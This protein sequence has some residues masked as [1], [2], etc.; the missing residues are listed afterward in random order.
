MMGS[1]ALR[2]TISIVT[3]CFNEEENV[4]QCYETVRALFDGPDAPLARYDFE[5]LFCD[6]G[7]QDRTVSILEEIAAADRRVKVIVNSRNFGAS[8]NLFNGIANATGDAVVASIAADLQDPP[9]MIPA[10]VEQWENGYEVVFGVRANRREAPPLTLARRLFYRLLN[11]FAPFEIPPDVGDFHLI[12]RVVADALRQQDDYYPYVRGLIAYSGFRSTGIRYEMRERL[13]GASKA[14]LYDLVD[15]ALNAFVSFGRVPMRLCLLAGLM[16]AAISLLVA[17]FFLVTNILFYRQL[18][19][20]GIPTLTIALFFF[21][22]VQLFFIG[23]LG[24]YLLATHAQVRRRPFV[25]ERRRINF[26]D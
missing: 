1:G 2:K 6:N 16:L 18:A 10:F 26:D 9:E 3:P 11:R 5:Y 8:L 12:D 20:P 25:I 13:R 7:S 4:R 21:S 23:M 14:S 19:P 17:L 15:L 24:E 22:G